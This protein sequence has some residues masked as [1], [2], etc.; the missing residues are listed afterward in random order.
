MGLISWFRKRTY[1]GICRAMI[2][3]Y[4]ATKE[5]NPTL[6]KP[7]LY[8]AV[9]SHRIPGWKRVSDTKCQFKSG[10]VLDMEEAKNFRDVVW[11]VIHD[12]TLP[13]PT[14]DP[15]ELE[16]YTECTQEI[17]DVLDEELGD[18]KDGYGRV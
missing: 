10:L 9:V 8:A 7:E 15:A 6:S 13:R 1:R 5:R 12:E 14:A 2:R 18:F 11:D 16:A 3:N 17:S 4:A